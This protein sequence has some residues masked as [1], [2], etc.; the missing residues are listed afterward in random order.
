M[1][2]CRFPTFYD[3]KRFFILLFNLKKAS[4]KTSPLKAP[5]LKAVSHLPIS[6][7]L[8]YHRLISR[9]KQLEKQKE[10]KSRLVQPTVNSVKINASLEALP[11]LKVVVQ[12]ENRFIQTAND[13]TAESKEKITVIKTTVNNTLAKQVLVKNTI[14]SLVSVAPSPNKGAT[15]SHQSDAKPS[16][17]SINKTNPSLLSS[18]QKTEQL[19]NN[20]PEDVQP[21]STSISIAALAKKPPKF[22]ASVLLNYV[23]RFRAQR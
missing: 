1:K 18:V 22:Q 19:P 10:Q 16:A 8:E 6:S 5:P 4:T 9:M 23:K 3:S 21:T 7:Q 11:L 14:N 15:V 20:Q 17:T 2:I 12:N 13:V